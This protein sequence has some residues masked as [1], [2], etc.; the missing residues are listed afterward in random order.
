MDETLDY[1]D[2][3]FRGELPAGERSSFEGRC[4]ADEEFASAVAFYVS[5]RQ[6]L[7]DELQE[8][9]KAEFQEL[10]HTLSKASAARPSPVRKLMP[11]MSV[12]AACLLLIVGWWIFF[13]GSGPR[14]LADGYID[15]HLKALPVTMSG[16]GDSLQ[17]GL[18]VYNKGDYD[19]AAA[20]FSA[21]IRKD[22]RDIE[23]RKYL[24]IVW[25]VKGDYDKAV[26][27]FDSLARR[28]DLYSNPGPFYKAITLMKRSAG[29][30]RQEAKRLLQEVVDKKLPGNEQAEKWIKDL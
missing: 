27:Q 18:D 4:A 24:G 28:Q 8:K 20:L 25:L 9:K 10:Y 2:R 21:L 15:H 29:E 19:Q 1:I 6:L 17:M 23:A 14:A 11:Y 26:V 16:R 22:G 30:D 12:A 13:R 5:T 7:R 3:Y